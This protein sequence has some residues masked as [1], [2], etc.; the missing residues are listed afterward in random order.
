MKRA[1]AAAERIALGLA[2]GCFVSLGLAPGASA[3]TVVLD[4]DGAV[5]SQRSDFQTNP[6]IEDVTTLAV[7]TGHYEFVVDPGG[8]ETDLALNID[9]QNLGLSHL[10]FS[11]GGGLPFDAVSLD[12]VNPADT[13]GEYTISAVG[14]GGGSIPAPTTAGAIALGPTFQGISALVITQNSPGA[15]AFDDLTVEVVPEP[16]AGGS[17]VAAALLLLLALRRRRDA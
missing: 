16:G 9:E 11:V 4:Y 5:P 17:L 3:S 15:F 1:S 13:A 6:Y 14:G 12:V 7:D 2:I 8:S 10:T